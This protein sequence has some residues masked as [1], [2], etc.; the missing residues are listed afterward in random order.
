MDA[1]V[2]KV[3]SILVRHVNPKFVHYDKPFLLACTVTTF[4]LAI[5]GVLLYLFLTDCVISEISQIG[6]EKSQ[7]KFIASARSAG[8]E[9]CLDGAMVMTT[10]ESDEISGSV[11]EEAPCVVGAGFMNNK[12][13]ADNLTWLPSKLVP[14]AEPGLEWCET[15][16]YQDAAEC[17]DKY[18]TACPPCDPLPKGVTQDT[19]SNLKDT[20][21]KLVYQRTVCPKTTHCI[22][23][24]MAFTNHIDV[25][26]ALLVVLV[27]MA[28]Q[29][30][31]QKGPNGT[32]HG[33]WEAAKHEVESEVEAVTE[34]VAGHE[35]NH[36]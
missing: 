24:A 5:F 14:F 13:P 11:L 22:G 36:A 10:F 8:A 30:V 26:L 15:A 31:F 29:C 32:L 4:S 12:W 20:V 28:C 2:N 17:M 16:A 27:F 35:V 18:G 7:I 25:L 23:A 21:F 9:M 34:A 3:K 6:G 33:L 1:K 19:V